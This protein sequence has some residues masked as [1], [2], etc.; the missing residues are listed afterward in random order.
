MQSIKPHYHFIV[1]RVLVIFFLTGA[2]K[3]CNAQ[4]LPIIPSRTISFDTE[5]ASYMDVDLSPDGKIIVFD[6]LG[7]IYTVPV[8]G[9]ETMELTRDACL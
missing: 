7:N 3:Y 1:V 5:E 2:T 9:G 4:K 6:I 8:S